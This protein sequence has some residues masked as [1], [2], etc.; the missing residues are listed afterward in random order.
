MTEKRLREKL[1]NFEKALL[2]LEEALK[3]VNIN[4]YV[5]NSVIK[6]FEF[7][8]ELTRKLMN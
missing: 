5:Y 7:T 2:R 8:Y 6:R 3:E 1:N 4:Q